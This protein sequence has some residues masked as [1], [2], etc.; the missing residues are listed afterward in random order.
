ML[1]STL[2]L[3]LILGK[4]GSNIHGGINHRVPISMQHLRFSMHLGLSMDPGYLDKPA[5]QAPGR[6]CGDLLDVIDQSHLSFQSNQMQSIN[7][8]KAS[9]PKKR[10]PLSFKAEHANSSNQFHLCVCVVLSSLF[11]FVR[12]LVAPISS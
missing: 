11:T 12:R 9:R 4:V 7:P 3:P 1:Q 10:I 2:W 6:R 5:G 8:G